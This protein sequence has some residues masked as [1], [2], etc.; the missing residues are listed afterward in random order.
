MKYYCSGC[1]EDISIVGYQETCMD[2]PYICTVCHT[3][4]IEIKEEALRFNE[5]KPNYAQLPLDLLDGAARVMDYGAKKYT[6]GNYRKGYTDLDS[7]LASLIRHV[8]SLQQSIHQEDL[9]GSKGALLD[10]SG[11]AH[12]HHVI[13]SALLLV[14]S[15]RLKGY[16]V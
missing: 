6:P 8:V 10:E 3:L 11:F 16:E 4:L 5:T 1:N 7:P 2:G 12:I 14:H 13:T 15:M 9:N